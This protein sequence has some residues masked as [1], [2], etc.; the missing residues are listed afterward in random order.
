MVGIQGQMRRGNKR[1]N[2]ADMKFSTLVGK[3]YD[4]DKEL[5]I[6]FPVDETYYRR[7][8]ATVVVVDLDSRPKPRRLRR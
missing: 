5:N 1:M 7:E 6:V 3:F 4:K 2:P 8:P